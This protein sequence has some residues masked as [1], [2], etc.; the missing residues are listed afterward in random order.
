MKALVDNATR[1]PAV[2]AQDAMQSNHPATGAPPSEPPGLFRSLF[3]EPVMPPAAVY[4]RNALAAEMQ[5]RGIPLQ[6][7]DNLP[8]WA[9]GSGGKPT[10]G[11]PTPPR[12]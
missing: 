4:D 10:P 11:Q 3:G 12:Y 5:R 9:G 6:N 8:T 1:P 7:T 2:Q